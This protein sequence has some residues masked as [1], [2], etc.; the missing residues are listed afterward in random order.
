MVKKIE[1]EIDEM[2]YNVAQQKLDMT[3]SEFLEYSLSMYIHQDDEYSTLFKKGAKLQNDFN[4]IR[5]RMYELEKRYD[6]NKDNQE[7]YDK[8]MITVDR[9]Y[10]ELGYI[11]KNQLNKIAN[12]NN[13]NHVDLIH[14]VENLQYKV[15]NFGALPK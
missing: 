10:S 3:L 13:L 1:L 9:I 2:L 15:T 6:E 14:Y 5:K 12:Q 11:G 7:Y 8:A 4:N